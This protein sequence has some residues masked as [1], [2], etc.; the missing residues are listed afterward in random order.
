[1][2]SVKSV[3]SVKYSIPQYFISNDQLSLPN[4]CIVEINLDRCLAWGVEGFVGVSR[5]ADRLHVGTPWFAFSEPFAKG[6]AML[7]SEHPSE[8]VPIPT[9]IGRDDG[10]SVNDA[11]NTLIAY[12]DQWKIP[13]AHD[14]RRLAEM[15]VE[16]KSFFE[17]SRIIEPVS[18]VDTILD[19]TMF[20]IDVPYQ[21]SAGWTFG[22]MGFER[23]RITIDNYISEL[24]KIG[25]WGDIILSQIRRKC[26]YHFFDVIGLG[27][28]EIVHHLC[29]WIV[30]DDP[31]QTVC[32]TMKGAFGLFVGEKILN[33]PCYRI[34]HDQL[35]V[36]GIFLYG[37]SDF[38]HHLEYRSSGVYARG[39]YLK[40]GE[41]DNL[42]FF[43]NPVENLAQF[44]HKTS[45]EDLAMNL[46][47]A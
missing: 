2:E 45:E 33:W 17:S 1:M 37:R 38:W 6:M 16:A 8:V 22:S 43:P 47:L 9:K 3:K 40:D 36:N 28:I 44:A 24:S 5:H 34:S 42:V 30:T 32:T 31:E 26:D 21:S 12:C 18:I 14:A 15:M 10:P 4:G 39:F 27:K 41:G 11:I 25:P 29:G 35:S 20:I 19:G 7:H 23:H 46:L 13:M